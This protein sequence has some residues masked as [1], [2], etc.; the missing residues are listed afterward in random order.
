MVN[1]ERYSSKTL[2][3]VMRLGDHLHFRKV[4]GS[5]SVILILGPAS[6][7]SK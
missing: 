7:S 5:R 3:K 1:F 4:N 2:S 6:I